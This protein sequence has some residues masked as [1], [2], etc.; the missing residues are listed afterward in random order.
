M[1]VYEQEERRVG[2]PR[3]KRAQQ[4]ILSAALEVLAEEGYEAMSVEG[5]AARARVGKTTIYRWWTS[6]LELAIDA[7]KTIHADNPIIETGNF[8]HDAIMM[9]RHVFFAWTTRSLSHKL[10][11][12]L[13][14]ELHEHH[15]LFATFNERLIAPRQQLLL[16]VVKRAQERGE[17][18]RDVEPMTLLIT[19]V[20]PIWYLFLFSDPDALTQEKV[21]HV[22]DTVL[23]GLVNR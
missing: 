22:V 2:R 23:E 11:F 4:A 19:I 8:R 10:V 7:L 3:S 5:V 6:K 9:L 20:G 14:G 1:T 16:E 12:R 15:E 17:L 18:R 13:L 21:E